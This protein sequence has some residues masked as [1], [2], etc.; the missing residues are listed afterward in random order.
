MKHGRQCSRKIAIDASH[1]PAGSIPV[2]MCVA[3]SACTDFSAYGNM[4][5]SAGH[6]IIYLLIMLRMVAEWKPTIFLHENVLHFPV[7]LL[8]EILD[9]LYH[10]EEYLLQPQHADFPV[11]RRRKYC[12]GRFRLKLRRLD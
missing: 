2:S 7:R 1:V 9:E 5:M 11:D 10:F 12:I 3:G 4:Q 6:T 8:V